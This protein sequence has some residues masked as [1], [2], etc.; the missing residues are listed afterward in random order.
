MWD[1]WGMREVIIIQI[2]SIIQIVLA[3]GILNVWLVRFNKTTRYRSKDTKNMKEEF[4]VYGLPSWSVY[5][6]GFF[7]L[8]SVSFLIIGLWIP[9]LVWNGFLILGI[10]MLGA[11]LMHIKVRDSFLKI[12]P[13]LSLLVLCVLGIYLISLV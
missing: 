8:L 9:S 13:A 2:I 7:K 11:V 1:D 6:V 10:L 12:L 4:I 3:L 5:I